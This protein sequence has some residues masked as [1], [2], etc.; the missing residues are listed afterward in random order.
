LQITLEV[1]ISQKNLN[2]EEAACTQ[3]HHTKKIRP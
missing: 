2:R 3:T 1:I